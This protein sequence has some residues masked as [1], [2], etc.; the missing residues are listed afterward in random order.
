MYIGNEGGLIGLVIPA[1]L[2]AV[3]LLLAVALK[4]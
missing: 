4:R 1:F 3:V 2:F